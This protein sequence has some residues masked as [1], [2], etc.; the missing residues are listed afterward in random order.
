MVDRPTERSQ[1]IRGKLAKNN[2]QLLVFRWNISFLFNSYRL[3]STKMHQHSS[4]EKRKRISFATNDLFL[5]D[6]VFIFSGKRKSDHKI[7]FSVV[8]DF[9]FK[10]YESLREIYRIFQTFHLQFEQSVKILS[11]KLYISLSPYQ[12][13]WK[14]CNIISWSCY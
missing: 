5:E 10:Q 11:L 6:H 12:L 2:S 3:F 4:F 1:E 7:T 13:G 14:W 9:E 8:F